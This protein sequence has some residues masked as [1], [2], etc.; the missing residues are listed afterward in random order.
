M[1]HPLRAMPD[2]V[3]VEGGL[4]A[5]GSA[6]S[7]AARARASFSSSAIRSNAGVPPAGVRRRPSHSSS[8]R[9]RVSASH[10]GSPGVCMAC[11][12]RVTRRCSLS[13]VFIAP[14]V[15]SAKRRPRPPGTGLPYT[16]P[17]AC[18]SPRISMRPHLSSLREAGAGESIDGRFPG[19]PERAVRNEA[20]AK[21]STRR[22]RRRSGPARPGPAAR[23]RRLPLSSPVPGR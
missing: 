13:C 11:A 22:G 18:T 21:R 12:T 19:H 14:P 3:A 10:R 2:P 8:L 6:A 23:Q 20:Q 7:R 1:K 5:H 15:F 9:A 4:R 16:R 17:C